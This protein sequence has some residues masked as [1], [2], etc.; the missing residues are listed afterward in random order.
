[1]VSSE[2]EDIHDPA[3][4]MPIRL[5]FFGMPRVIAGTDHAEVSGACLREVLDHAIARHPDLA[6]HLLDPDSGWLNRGYTFVVNGLFTSDPE[7]PVPTGAEVL[8]VSR[9]SGG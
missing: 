2:S 6:G 7:H 9:A 4:H 3:S 5:E 1:M 8:L